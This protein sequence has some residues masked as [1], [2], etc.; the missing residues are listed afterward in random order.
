MTLSWFQRLFHRRPAKDELLN[1]G[2]A[3]AMNWGE[4]WLSPING[5]LR[6]RYPHLSEVE[7]EQINSICQS[8]MRFASEI[9]LTLLRNGPEQLSLARFGPI[10]KGR[11]EWV[12][13]ENLARLV[14]QGVY[15][16]AKMGGHAREA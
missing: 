5:R 1:E 12:N 8:A 3:L 15:Y 14:N 4:N 10:V 7:L 9:A 16:A 11:Y 2:L 6:E 13:Q